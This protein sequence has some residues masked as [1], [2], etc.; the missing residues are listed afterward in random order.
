MRVMTLYN[1][2][3]G[4]GRAAKAG[5]AVHDALAAAGHEVRLAE[6]SLGPPKQWLDPQMSEVEL[7]VVVGGDGAM[8][9]ASG[10]AGRNRRPLYHYPVGTE[11]LCAREFGTDRSLARLLAAIERFE[12]KHF[13]VGTANG[14]DF[15]LMASVGYDAEVVADLAA[16]RGSRITHMTYLAPMLRQFARF[17]P[18]RLT[19]TVDGK[20]VVEDREG[21]LVVG[22]SRQYARRFDPAC[23]ASMTD[24][25]LDVV[26]FPT[27]SRRALLGWAIACRLR[28]HVARDRLVYRLGREVEVRCR[29]A[30]RYQ[31]DGDPPESLPGDETRAG[32]EGG[33]AERVVDLR[34]SLCPSILP[35][36]IP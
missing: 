16:R 18:P 20:P 1:P 14:R 12:V 4:A 27:R 15:L 36:L 31:L 26:F 8:R 2:I 10:A 7:I 6:T 17:S 13:D 32:A 23:R 5:R 29:P 9:L 22:N 21:C 35:V 3:A 33:L 30:R 19:V 11:N 24:G 25:L 28:R 34:I